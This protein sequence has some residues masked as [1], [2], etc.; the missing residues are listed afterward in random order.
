[1]AAHKAIRGEIQTAPIDQCDD[2][3]MDLASDALIVRSRVAPSIS[4][5]TGE[6]FWCPT[7]VRP[8]REPKPWPTVTREV[9]A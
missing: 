8:R 2:A 4:A 7:D 6:R 9:T 5:L 1:M 3:A